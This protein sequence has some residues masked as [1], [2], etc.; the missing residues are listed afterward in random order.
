MHLISLGDHAQLWRPDS[1]VLAR[2]QVHTA[3]GRCRGQFGAQ[4]WTLWHRLQ[5]HPRWRI[6][7]LFKTTSTGLVITLDY[8]SAPIDLL[9]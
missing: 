5:R 9:A 1:P 4:I 6:A 7:Y 2:I 8:D 3:P